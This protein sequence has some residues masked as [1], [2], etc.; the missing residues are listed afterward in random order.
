MG[1]RERESRPH[2]GPAGKTRSSG[3]ADGRHRTTSP[4]DSSTSAASMSLSVKDSEANSPGTRS[5]PCRVGIRAVDCDRSAAYTS[6]SA[7]RLQQAGTACRIARIR[8]MSW[9]R[10]RAR[11]GQ[12]A[13][14]RL[15]DLEFLAL[16]K[17]SLEELAPGV[18]EGARLRG[19]SLMS[20]TR[21][22][23]VGVLPNTH[24]GPDHY[25]LAAMPDVG[26]QP[27]VPVFMD[28]VVAM[29]G[30][31]RHA[32]ASWAQTAGAC[33]LEL[34]DRHG[35]YAEHDGPDDERGVP[36]FHAITP[37]STTFG[38][39]PGENQRLQHALLEANVLHRVADSFT[40]DLYSPFFN[41]IK[42][43]WGGLPGKMQAEIRVNGDCNE[44]ASAAMA[45]LNLPEPSAFTAV[46]YYALLL[47][48][49]APAGEPNYPE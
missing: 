26:I 3:E 46:R 41:G 39:D 36:G 38:L 22:W 27:D 14:G 28:Y 6:P 43:Y 34:L 35:R 7:A 31:P 23:A 4:F 9:I 37:G 5:Y 29:N 11:D 25:D 44:E 1:M 2:V 47:P 49:S 33:L 30:N 12:S 32:A 15:P 40:K 17:A 24:G 42:V 45:A 18:T 8:R 20:R 21:G 16:V 13:G 19:N 48:V 10:R